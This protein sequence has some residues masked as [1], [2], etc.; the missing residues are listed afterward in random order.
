MTMLL[1]WCVGLAAGA[2]LAAG[3]LVLCMRG[4][5]GQPEL[6]KL[7]PWRY[8]HRGLHDETRPENSLAAFRAAVERGYGAELD[9]HLLADGTL[10]VIHDSLLRR[11]TGQ[12]GRVED[13]TA[14]ELCQYHLQ[15]TR[16]TIPTFP[17]VLALFQGKAPLIVELKVEN[18]CET[19]CQ[20]AARLLDAYPGDYCIESFDP[21][22]VY[23]F[24]KHRPQVIRG[25]L[26][27][28][29]FRTTGKEMP[30]LL[31]LCLT[32]QLF[33]WLTKPDF[34][35][36][37]FR[38]HRTISNTIVTKLWHMAA[39]AWT[40]RTPEALEEAEREGWLPIFEKFIP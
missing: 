12:E 4:R 22:A 1:K 15:G 33:N 36:Y 18:N 39:A 28:N 3:A 17:E 20:A 26:T 6:E 9:I 24:K 29:Y 16:E 40:L 30:W 27:E 21:R 14:G 34:V 13:L 5:S 31:K 19:L 10:A 38:D 7:R 32:H 35:A 11:T 23:W 8:A 2:A 37:C 25:Q